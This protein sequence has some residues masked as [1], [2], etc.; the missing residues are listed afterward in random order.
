MTTATE[1]ATQAARAADRAA[2]SSDDIQR[3]LGRVEGDVRAILITIAE[4]AHRHEER[5]NSHDVRLRSVEQKQYLVLGVW[6]VITAAGG[7]LI[8][9]FSA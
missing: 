4:T 8:H 6:G 3:S 2:S 9:R 1:A 7:W 5:L